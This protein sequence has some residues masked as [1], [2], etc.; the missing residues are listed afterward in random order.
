MLLGAAARLF[1]NL[2]H[3]GRTHWWIP[4]AVAVA[5]VALALAIKPDDESAASGPANVASGRAVFADAG[6]GD[7]HTLADAGAT[8]RVGPNL[9]SAKPSSELVLERVRN[10]KGVMP[11]FR[12]E[13]NDAEL[14][15]VAAYVAQV[16]GK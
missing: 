5:G 2:R 9:D 13:L 11:S 3:A 1:F 8:G 10:G 7:C 12:G 4:A 6:C 16:A 15:A 14:E